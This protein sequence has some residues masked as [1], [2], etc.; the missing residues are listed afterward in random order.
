MEDDWVN[1]YGLSSTDI[2]FSFGNGA[3]PLGTPDSF[4]PDLKLSWNNPDVVGQTHGFDQKTQPLEVPRV[5]KADFID[6][7]LRRSPK[8]GKPRNGAEAVSEVSNPRRDLSH[9]EKQKFACP[10][11][12]RNPVRYNLHDY[13]SCALSSFQEISQVM[14]VHPYFISRYV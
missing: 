9:D 7:E 8:R 13:R 3:E 1:P 10:F 2:E 12:K 11:Q 5:V 6:V 4:K 14:Y